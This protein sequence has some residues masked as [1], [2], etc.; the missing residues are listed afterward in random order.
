MKMKTSEFLENGYTLLCIP[1]VLTKNK[2]AKTASGLACAPTSENANRW[3]ALGGLYAV[4][5]VD[6]HHGIHSDERARSARSFLSMASWML[7]DRDIYTVNDESEDF[8]DIA[9]LY[10]F[11]IRLAKDCGE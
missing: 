5:G 1:G 3:C 7:F 9:Y 11:A 2:M 10:E 4:C 6:T 8:F